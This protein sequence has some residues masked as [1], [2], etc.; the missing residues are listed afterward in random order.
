M[1]SL[2]LRLTKQRRLPARRSPLFHPNLLHLQ[3]ERTK[4]HRQPRGLGNLP[5]SCL[6]K[7]QTVAKEGERSPLL[8][9]LSVSLS[10]KARSWKNVRVSR[11]ERKASRFIFLSSVSTVLVTMRLYTNYKCKLCNF[12]DSAHKHSCIFALNWCCTT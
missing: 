10:P 8:L 7:P 6:L 11:S 5:D 2:H 12:D 3:Q 9:L 4:K 1:R